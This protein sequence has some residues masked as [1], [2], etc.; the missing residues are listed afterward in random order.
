MPSMDAVT[1]TKEVTDEPILTERQR[2]NPQLQWVDTFSRVLDTKFRVPGTKQRFGVDFVLGLIPGVGD[3]LS[4]SMS[5][6]LIATMARH[7]ASPRLVVRMLINV[8]LDATIGAVPVLGNVFDFFYKANYRNA[9]LMREYYEEG[10]HQGS[11]W[12]VVAGVVL[13]ILLMIGV[14]FWLIIELF[15][16][17]F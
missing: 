9:E 8:F 10:R 15:S 3:V 14:T 5:G 16:W 6:V 13:A 7:G 1:I 11:I 12:P 2:E 4:L 17:I